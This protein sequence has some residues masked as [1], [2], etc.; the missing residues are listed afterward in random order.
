MV[1]IIAFSGPI[2][3]TIGIYGH[4]RMDDGMVP[5]PCLLL[6]LLP[7]L[8]APIFLLQPAGTDIEANVSKT[9]K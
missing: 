4:L 1:I 8:L 2:R 3:P 7:T 6:L 9:H 5:F